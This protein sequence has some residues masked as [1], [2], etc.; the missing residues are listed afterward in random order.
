MTR[1]VPPPGVR[2]VG[3]AVAVGMAAGVVFGVGDVVGDDAGVA[4]PACDVETG[5]ET[6]K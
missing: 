1:N 5:V 4:A 2:V 3:A 6:R